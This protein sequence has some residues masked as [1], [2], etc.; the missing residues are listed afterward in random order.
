MHSAVLVSHIYTVLFKSHKLCLS[1]IN[2]L[3]YQPNVLPQYSEGNV[4]V[5]KIDLGTQLIATFSSDPEL[6]LIA[7]VDF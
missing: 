5:L 4:V 3:L 7:L 6:L 1:L 2:T